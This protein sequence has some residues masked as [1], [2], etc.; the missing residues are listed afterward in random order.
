MTLLIYNPVCLQFEK[1]P[2]D[3][4]SGGKASY[5]FWLFV[6]LS[7]GAGDNNGKKVVSKLTVVTE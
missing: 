5:F 3:E 4:S 1:V 2:R 6:L 7:Q